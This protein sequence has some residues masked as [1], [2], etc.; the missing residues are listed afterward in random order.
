M[1]GHT[2]GGEHVLDREERHALQGSIH[3]VNLAT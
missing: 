2:G 3:P 1:G